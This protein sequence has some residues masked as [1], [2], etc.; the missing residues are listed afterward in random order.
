M[1]ANAGLPNAHLW[2]DR[3]PGE[4]LVAVHVNSG[5]RVRH[6][7]NLA[8]RLRV[9]PAGSRFESPDLAS[10][11]PLAALLEPVNAAIAAA[12]RRVATLVDPHFQPG[13][14]AACAIH[15]RI[16]GPCGSSRVC[17]LTKR[18][19]PVVPSGG[20]GLN[21]APPKKTIFTETS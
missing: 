21:S 13:T 15:L 6:E 8:S 1:A 12:D 3:D 18:V 17:T 5:Q 4:Q 2:V 7:D 9:A 16:S 11:S 20:G 19:R 10:Q 14:W